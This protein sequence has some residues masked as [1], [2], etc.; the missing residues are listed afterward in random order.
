MVTKNVPPH[1]PERARRQN[2]SAPAKSP[3]RGEGPSASKRKRIEC[4]V[5]E[6]LPT[7]PG[8]TRAH[9][10]RRSGRQML[11][12]DRAKGERIR[13]NATTEIVILEIGPGQ[14]RIAIETMSKGEGQP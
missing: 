1:G 2:Q 10:V 3:G 8:K 4:E 11:V 14:V 6:G 13:I 12:V 5:H 9:Y 7:V